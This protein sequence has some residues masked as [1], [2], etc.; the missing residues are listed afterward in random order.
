[1][2]Y[3]Q[4]HNSDA[5]STY[6]RLAGLRCNFYKVRDFARKCE[7]NFSSNSVPEQNRIKAGCSLCWTDEKGAYQI[8]IKR[9]SG[10]YWALISASGETFKN[11]YK[12]N[13]TES[14]IKT[15]SELSNN[16]LIQKV[17]ADL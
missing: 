1:M 14:I 8:T 6:L 5:I 2:I 13:V 7:Q 9:M 4:D 3:I 17:E 16:N 15:A 10:G 12:D 11:Q